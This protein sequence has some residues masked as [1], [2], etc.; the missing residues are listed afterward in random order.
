M[1]RPMASTST[2]SN[3]NSVIRSGP[4]PAGSAAAFSNTIRAPA[5]AFSNTIR[6]W[7]HPCQL[8]A[9]VEM[10][11][12]KSKVREQR[13]EAEVKVAAASAVVDG[14]RTAAAVEGP[15]QLPSPAP[16]MSGNEG[17]RRLSV[18]KP[19]AEFHHKSMYMERGVEGVPQRTESWYS[20]EDLEEASS[21][22]PPFA[23]FEIRQ[24]SETWTVMNC[25]LEAVATLAV[26]RTDGYKMEVAAV[27]VD[28]S[29]KAVAVAS[30]SGEAHVL[31][32]EGGAVR[33]EVPPT[34]LPRTSIAYSCDGALLACGSCD[35]NLTLYDAST[36]DKLASS[37]AHDSFVTCVAFAT[38]NPCVLASGAGDKP[39]VRVW[40]V[41]LPDDATGKCTLQ[42]S[43]VLV[44]HWAFVTNLAFSGDDMSLCS[45]SMDGT[46]RLW[47]IRNGEPMANMSF[48]VTV[49]DR[50]RMQSRDLQHVRYRQ[51]EAELVSQDSEARFSWARQDFARPLELC[52]VSDVDSWG[53]QI[54]ARFQ[55]VDVT[56][57][58]IVYSSS[59][60]LRILR[61][62]SG[63]VNSVTWS[64]DGATVLS[65]GD[66]GTVRLWDAQCV[67]NEDVILDSRFCE[68]TEGHPWNLI[69][70]EMVPGETACAM[71]IDADDAV[72]FRIEYAQ[73]G[74][75]ARHNGGLPGPAI[76]TRRHTPGF[77]Q[78]FREPVYRIIREPEGLQVL[79]TDASSAVFRGHQGPVTAAL[80]FQAW[81]LSVS[82]DGTLRVWDTQSQACLRVVSNSAQCPLCSLAVSEAEPKMVVA[83]DRKGGVSMMAAASLC[84]E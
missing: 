35:K 78:R 51:M 19:A 44:G 31:S 2:K 57:G 17:R 72:N 47:D 16:A 48:N 13:E 45:C 41:G 26:Q 70:D 34:R 67:R 50:T 32:I 4:A 15:T 77:A 62:H 3:S 29:S 42:E 76:R 68:G 30:K 66:D 69:E 52:R 71:V 10:G 21:Q 54:E 7:R 64:S 53:R 63:P 6:T 24:S 8:V 46:L 56:N 49:Q 83:A 1:E 43:C 37:S 28:R 27:S 59:G 61:G 80:F 22:R 79:N 82:D 65:A 14:D 38:R 5:A 36:G 40:H 18:S 20:Q 84:T 39:I 11:G 75:F 81:V 12:G 33:T 9:S 23:T 60:W 74:C 73:E 25:D 55:Y 58:E